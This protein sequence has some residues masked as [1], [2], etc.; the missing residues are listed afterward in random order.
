MNWPWST[1]AGLCG[2]PGEWYS[3]LGTCFPGGEVG[4][5]VWTK[6]RLCEEDFV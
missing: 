4:C 5:L 3:N 1:L 2:E 6:C